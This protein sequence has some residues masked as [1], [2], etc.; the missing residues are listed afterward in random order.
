VVLPGRKELQGIGLVAEA[1]PQWETELESCSINRFLELVVYRKWRGASPAAE[2]RFGF[3]IFITMP[4]DMLAKAAGTPQL[5]IDPVAD[6]T[7]QKGDECGLMLGTWRIIG[8]FGHCC[9]SH[10][11][12]GA[13]DSAPF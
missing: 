12:V 10:D 13:K 4:D 7:R 2:V 9:S 11:Y 6:F 5:K 3:V 1:I 8:H